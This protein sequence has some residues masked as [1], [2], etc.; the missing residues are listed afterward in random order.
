MHAGHL[1]RR[2]LDSQP[3]R[4]HTT[5]GRRLGL[6][7][8][9]K[10]WRAGRLRTH[11][12]RPVSPIDLTMVMALLSLVVVVVDGHQIPV[13][14]PPELEAVLHGQMPP[15][16]VAGSDHDRDRDTVT[17]TSPRSASTVQWSQPAR[18]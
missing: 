11:G 8:G 5:T 2:P 3:H 9:R 4:P 17:C 6:T 14:Q 1:F 15:Q 16:V 12:Y 10:R 7:G 18:S 13:R